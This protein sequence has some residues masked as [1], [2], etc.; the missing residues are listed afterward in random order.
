MSINWEHDAPKEELAFLVK[1][2]GEPSV[3][4]GRAGGLAIWDMKTLQ[5]GKLFGLPNCFDEYEIR[6]ESVF[7][8]FPSEHY[9]NQ[10]ASIVVDIDPK[11]L[12]FILSLSGSVMYDPL[13]RLLTARCGDI[14][15]NIATLYLAL[16]ILENPMRVKSI[17]ENKLYGRLLKS[18]YKFGGVRGVNKKQA[19]NVYKQLCRLK[20][21]LPQTPN[22]GFWRGAFNQYGG[23]VQNNMENHMDLVTQKKA[24]MEQR[25]SNKMRN[26]QEKDL[27]SRIWANE[28]HKKSYVD[29]VY[30]KPIVSTSR[31][32]SNSNTQM[33]KILAYED[34][35]GKD[36]N[37]GLEGLYENAEY[38][39]VEIT[40][41]EPFSSGRPQPRD[42]IDLDLAK[43]YERG[44][45]GDKNVK[46][47]SIEPFAAG[48]KVEDAF[49]RITDTD[50]WAQQLATAEHVA[51][52]DQAGTHNRSNAREYFCGRRSYNPDIP[53]CT[54]HNDY[55]ANRGCS[56]CD[57]YVKVYHTGQRPAESTDPTC[58]YGRKANPYVDAAAY[59]RHFEDN[60]HD[61]KFYNNFY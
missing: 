30:E 13:K 41:V 48:A 18:M 36:I 54:S 8:K 57:N 7:H 24:E 17:Q 34:K 49:D 10:Y 50:E 31:Q 52:S 1:L 58:F 16:R 19:T 25:R 40:G 26:E 12:Q 28:S 61:E 32:A 60:M 11:S 45:Y 5:K 59:M 33:N 15:A 23:K 43:L 27:T 37:L 55:A 4:E 35:D 6:D 29:K 3:L 42:D 46:I 22:K 38:R 56:A 39:D 20:R 14:F 51:N 53:P 2:F 44:Q 47:T 21:D 9:D